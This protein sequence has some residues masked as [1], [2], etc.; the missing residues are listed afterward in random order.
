[1]SG[2]AGFYQNKYDFKENPVWPNKLRAM[3]ESL[4]EVP[5]GTTFLYPHAGMVSTTDS[6]FFS[7]LG[8]IFLCGELY[9]ANDLRGFLVSYLQSGETESDAGI[10]LNG[11]LAIGTGFFKQ[12]NGIFAFAIYDERRDCLL[13]VRDPLG[14]K[15][16]F[17]Q[18]YEDCFVFGS[19]QKALFAYGINPCAD[20]E[21]FC[22]VLGLGPARTPGHGVY[23]A[24]REVLPGHMIIKGPGYYRDEAFFTLQ[25]L[26]HVDT[27]EETRDKV[28]WLINDNI[29]RQLTSPASLGIL[30]S[31]GLDS[32]L[33][34]AFARQELNKAGG[35][36]K[37]F[38]FDF[39]GSKENFKP[40]AFQSS[41]DR[42]FV[43]IMAA[44]LGS[45]HTYLECDSLTQADYL[46][47][48]VDARDLPCMADIE[49]SLLYFAGEVA[50]DCPVVL[51]GEGADEIF[52]GYPWFHKEELWQKNL[53]P[54]SYDLSVR[55]AL[56]KED[57]LDSLGLTEYVQHA[58]TKSLAETPRFEGDNETE[59]RRREIAWLNIRWFMATLLNRLNRAGTAAGLLTR[60]PLADIR[61]L[62]YVYNIPWA[63]KCENGKTKSLLINAGQ[64]LLP[65]EILYRKKSPYPKTYDQGYEKLLAK[66]LLERVT[67]LASPLRPIIDVT[68]VK[69]Y[70]A[71]GFNYGMPW[72]GQ[73][74]AGPQMLAYLLQIDYW[75]RK[76]RLTI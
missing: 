56:L 26:E 69:A 61:L 48:A 31:G 76:Y 7:G 30:L 21:I 51:T 22:E 42:P 74:M 32:S 36:L 63:L 2:I 37:T 25:G 54:W 72:Y 46:D 33:V 59:T 14:A 29:K 70:I 49:S 18:Q 8:S 44:A 17:Y 15:P 16:L 73:L 6:A 20:R 13:I 60:T 27:A 52:G 67:D 58:Y 12:L 75:M 38:S 68:K 62:Q 40:S 53:F 50:K 39:V 23:C 66:R 10:I 45:E 64:D 4:Q 5:S 9:N 65:L 35:R 34:A 11:Y 47:K 55:T 24:M 28:S 43:G 1:M 57:F 19:A 41:L 3:K 71:G